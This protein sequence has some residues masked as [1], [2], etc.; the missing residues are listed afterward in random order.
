VQEKLTPVINVTNN[1]SYVE[2]PSMTVSQWMEVWLKD[3]RKN[4]A[5]PKTYLDLEGCYCLYVKPELGGYATTWYS[6]L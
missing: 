1:D 2:P 4:S 5:K 6:A 3:Y